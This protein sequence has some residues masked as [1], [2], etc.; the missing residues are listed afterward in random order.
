[1]RI[2]VALPLNLLLWKVLLWTKIPAFHNVVK[3]G[4]NT[5]ENDAIKRQNKN[6]L[7]MAN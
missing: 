6:L 1:M 2:A 7:F 5:V 4:Q 3:K